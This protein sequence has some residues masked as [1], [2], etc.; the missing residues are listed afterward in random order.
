M[1]LD[2]FAII[3][4]ADLKA[5]LG[6]TVS[7]Y[8]AQLEQAINAA[9]YQIESYLDRKVVQRR[10]Y[11]WTTA[12]GQAN[13][14]LK[15]PPVGHVHYLA[16]GAKAAMT[17]SSTVSTD[18]ACTVTLVEG[19]MTLVR[20]ASSGTET[21]E[22][23]NFSNHPTSTA[24]V[25]HV[26]GLTGWKASLVTN[27]LAKHLHRFAGRD[28]V[29]A[30]LTMTFADNAQFDTRVDNNTGIVYLSPSAYPDEESDWPRKPL[31]I[32]ADYDGGYE[33]V[34]ED[35]KAACRLLAGAIY[36]A[37]QRDSGLTAESLGDYSY[38][39][40]TRAVSETEAMR[41]LQPFRR[42]R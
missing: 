17:I 23:I 22:Q 42:L 14:I 24:I 37:R 7:T 38:T 10:F 15:N 25:A 11:E 32:F 30:N 16:S 29:N 3:T 6:I 28:V 33:A 4:L 2:E 26:N 31:T 35:L 1:A 13:V 27:C 36:Y 21:I 34:P 20:V 40:D 19:R 9:T 39:I 18:I 8:D 5:T 12:R 41:L